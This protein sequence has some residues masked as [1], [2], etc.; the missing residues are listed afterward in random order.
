MP[1]ITNWYKTNLLK[2]NTSKTSTIILCNIGNPNENLTPVTIEEHDCELNATIKYLGLHIDSTLSWNKHILTIKNKVT[3]LIRQFARIRTHL[4]DKLALLFYTSLI[5]PKIEYASST[6]FNMSSTNSTVLETLQNGCMRIIDKS[7]PLT[8]SEYLR[9]KLNL[10]TLKNRRK[11]WYLLDYHKLKYEKSPTIHNNFS[12]EPEHHH[13]LR[14]ANKAF[15]P[16]T[17][18]TA[19]QRALHALGAKTL[20]SIPDH[21]A[22]ITDFKMFKIELEKYLLDP[23][24]QS[25]LPEDNNPYTY[26]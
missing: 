22:T 1:E 11:Y 25:L 12:D 19:G 9:I 6:L 23:L 14:N 3:P 16:R 20:N 8:N 4:S 2:L 24:L 7:Q 26:Y 5:R 21:I 10:P 15:V 13:D 17:N 18:K